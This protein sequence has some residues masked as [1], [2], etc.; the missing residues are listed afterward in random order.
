M[1]VG[2]TKKKEDKIDVTIYKMY[3]LRI[4]TTMDSRLSRE[5]L[6]ECGIYS[7][8]KPSIACAEK[9]RA[10][11]GRGG[12]RRVHTWYMLLLLLLILRGGSQHPYLLQRAQDQAHFIRRHFSVIY[13]WFQKPNLTIF[14]FYEQDCEVFLLNLKKK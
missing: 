5:Y 13:L 3:A 14:F 8:L 10:T 12:G 1:R 11:E 6:L 9:G 7:L 2:R 4:E